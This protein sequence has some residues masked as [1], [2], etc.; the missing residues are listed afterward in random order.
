MEQK[1]Q[2]AC[3]QS[4]VRFSLHSTCCQIF[5]GKNIPKPEKAYTKCPQNI[6]NARKLLQ[7]AINYNNI[8]HPKSLEININFWYETIPSGK[9]LLILRGAEV[10]KLLQVF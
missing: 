5:L 8:I 3:Y 6:P 1:Y 7:R 2:N 4:I 9:L 10:V